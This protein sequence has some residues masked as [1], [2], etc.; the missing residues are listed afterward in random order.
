MPRRD[1]HVRQPDDHAVQGRDDGKSVWTQR[2]LIC[3][4][5]SRGLRA[6]QMPVLI[7]FGDPAGAFVI[8]S[9]RLKS[10]DHVSVGQTRE[11]VQK[12]EACD[13]VEAIDHFRMQRIAEIEHEVAISREPVREQRFARAKLQLGV[14]R[15]EALFTYW[16]RRDNSSVA[17]AFGRKVYDGEKVAILSVLVT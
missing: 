17:I 2:R 9:M 10:D 11:T 14:M 16:G 8:R 15:P 6:N 3:R 5:I 4:R 7:E 13:A 12:A 1:R